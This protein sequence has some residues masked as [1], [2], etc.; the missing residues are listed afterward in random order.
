LIN[1]F[2]DIGNIEETVVQLYCHWLYNDVIWLIFYIGAAI[3][4]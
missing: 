4:V 2:D 1:R 3:W